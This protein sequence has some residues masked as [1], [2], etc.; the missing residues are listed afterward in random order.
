M[1][2]LICFNVPVYPKECK[3]CSKI[4]CDTCLIKYRKTKSRTMPMCCH[5]K[6]LDI[7]TFRDMQSKIL[8]DIMDCIKV[9]HKCTK[10]KD[11]EVY[12]I[13]ELKRHVE[14]GEC[15]GYSLRCFCGSLDKF[16]L[17]GLK[18]HLREECDHV[19]IQCKYCHLGKD[20]PDGPLDA[21]RLNHFNDN[22]MTR[23][24][25]REHHCWKE[26][27]RIEEGIFDQDNFAQLKMLL[28]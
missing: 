25:F 6:T 1:R 7:N 14:S 2:C 28:L 22:S 19:R 27:L 9:G 12:T 26:Q 17:D 13:G 3:N 5:C 11:V 20:Y 24:Q 10:F 8:K 21:D 4:V 16:G 15:P 18:K 23:H